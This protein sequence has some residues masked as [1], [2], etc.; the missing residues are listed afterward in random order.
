MDSMDRVNKTI[1]STTSTNASPARVT[2]TIK[3]VDL[4]AA[5]NYGREQSNVSKKVLD[6]RDYWFYNNLYWKF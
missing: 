2:R 1:T 5:A 3:K 6:K 4:G